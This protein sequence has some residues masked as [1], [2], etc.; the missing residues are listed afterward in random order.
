MVWARV[1]TI[2]D[3]V[4]LFQK[5][6]RFIEIQGK[7]D[8]YYLGFVTVKILKGIIGR[9]KACIKGRKNAEE[10]TSVYRYGRD[11]SLG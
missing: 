9:I 10:I 4:L 6:D 5:G 7:G 3:H 1:N 11:R 8:R 2:F